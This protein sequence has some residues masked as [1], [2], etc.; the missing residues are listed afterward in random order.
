[1]SQPRRAAKQERKTNV[2]SRTLAGRPELIHCNSHAQQRRRRRS[3][4]VS[5]GHGQVPFRQPAGTR[6]KDSNLLVPGQTIATSQDATNS[7]KAKKPACV[8]KTRI[9]SGAGDR[10]KNG[11]SKMG[12]S[13]DKTRQ[14]WGPAQKPPSPT[15]A[16]D[17]GEGEKSNTHMKIQ[18][19][20]CHWL[21][22][23][24]GPPF[25]H[26]RCLI[27]HHSSSMKR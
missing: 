5:G 4:S 26:L 20:R 23:Q 14:D 6:L 16:M 8:R 11:P 12:Q 10:G 17:S 7:P 18:M 21:A 25:A 27:G 1:M 3:V 13:Q 15:G 24:V 22:G 19:V 9:L 2:W